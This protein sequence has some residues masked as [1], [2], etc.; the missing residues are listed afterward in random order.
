MADGFAAAF[1]H[2][3]AWET[4]RF[5]DHPWDAGGATKH[6]VTLRTLRAWRGRPTTKA[7]VAQLGLDEAKAIYRARYW[8]V[9]RCGDL[10]PALALAVFDAAVLQGPGSA[11]K[12]LQRAVGSKAD[13]IIGP[14]T[15]AAVARRDDG[16]TL[17]A[18]ASY[19]G[20]HFTAV[21]SFAKTGR[22]W[23]RRLANTHRIA[24]G[25]L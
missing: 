4:P 2:I 18:F 17:D 24:A 15:L 6:G 3:Y 10:P 11:A 7:D 5:T 12:F 19:R 14:R 22:G 23:F 16:D 13:G 20:V 21:K 9:C 25:L 8:R 1:A